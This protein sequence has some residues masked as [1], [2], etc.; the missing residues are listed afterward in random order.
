[1]AAA[2]TKVPPGSEQAKALSECHFK[3]GKTV[4]PGASSPAGVTNA[5]KNMAMQRGRMAPQAGAMATHAG[6]PGGAAPPPAA[7]PMAM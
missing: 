4:E 1:M 5:F 3:L 7:P 2:M 6:A